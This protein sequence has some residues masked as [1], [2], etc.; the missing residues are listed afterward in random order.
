MVSQVSF[1]FDGSHNADPIVSILK[2]RLQNLKYK[3]EKEGQFVYRIYV[4]STQTK[5]ETLNVCKGIQHFA[6]YDFNREL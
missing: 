2:K 3:I 1:K 5:E 6:M 4:G